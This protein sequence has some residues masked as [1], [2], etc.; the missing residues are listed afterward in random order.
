GTNFGL[1]RETVL[2]FLLG[3]ILVRGVAVLVRGAADSLG[4]RAHLETVGVSPKLFDMLLA[5]MKLFFYL[6]VVEIA[7][8]QLGVSARILDTTLV[9]MSYG[10]VLLLVL[11]GFFGFRDLVRN[12]AA[13]IYL[14]GSEV[15]KPGKRVKVDDEAGEIREI[16]TFATTITTDSG[17]FL[18]SPNHRLMNSDILFKRVS[19]D[20]ETLEDI[21]DYFVTEDSAYRGAAVG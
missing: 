5:G 16:S 21:K 20:I 10:V 15:L 6:V 19:A 3:V 1:D 13:G 4:M 14:R 9:A 7:I 12:Y 17:Y 2:A 11:L 8:V 18:L